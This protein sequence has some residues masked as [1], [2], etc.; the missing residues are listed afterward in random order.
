MGHSGLGRDRRRNA[1][2]SSFYFCIQF[3]S[4]CCSYR[5][6]SGERDAGGDTDSPRKDGGDLVLPKS[7]LG[8]V[9]ADAGRDAFAAAAQIEST[10][11]RDPLESSFENSLETDCFQR[12]CVRN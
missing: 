7:S 12:L 10:L 4:G 2:A 1:Q 9:A 11:D 3:P 8:D 5:T 6:D